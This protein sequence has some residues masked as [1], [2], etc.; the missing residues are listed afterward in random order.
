MHFFSI[1]IF[2][3]KKVTSD[4]LTGFV[5]SAGDLLEVVFALLR[6]GPGQWA[7]GTKLRCAAEL[8]GRSMGILRSESLQQL[9]AAIRSGADG[10]GFRR[11]DVLMIGW[12]WM[13]PK[14][15]VQ[16]EWQRNGARAEKW[17][18]TW[19]PANRRS[20]MGFSR[21]PVDWASAAWFWPTWRCSQCSSNQNWIHMDT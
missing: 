4:F 2:F 21:L 20:E 1:S 19:C 13:A 9:E 14:N 3:I 12:P 17:D 10:L 15:M 18:P 7:V 8:A 16:H 5:T 11:L 6:F